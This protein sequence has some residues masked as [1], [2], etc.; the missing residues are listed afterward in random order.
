MSGKKKG[1]RA[2]TAAVATVP[3]PPGLDP[4]IAEYLFALVHSEIQTLTSSVDENRRLLEGINT[5]L[6][7]IKISL[8]NCYTQLEKVKDVFLPSLANRVTEIA[9]SLAERVLDMDVHSRKWSL[10][11]GGL[12]GAAGEDEAETRS[13]CVKLAQD[14]GVPA[15]ETTH[16]AACHR[17][18]H[19][20]ANSSVIVRFTDLGDREAWLSKA[21]HLPAVNSGLSMSPDLPPVL[22][23]LK[24]ELLLIRRDLPQAEKKNTRVKYLARFPYVEMAYKDGSKPTLRPTK[25]KQQLLQDVLGFSPDIQFSYN[26]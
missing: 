26:D 23:K 7:E 6:S 1:A 22:R 16:F 18:Q 21:R 11:I 10:V 13:K 9:T 12:Q 2:T 3:V 24:T 17:L 19:N 25:T 5:D 4:K 20:K 8:N 15:A 14:I